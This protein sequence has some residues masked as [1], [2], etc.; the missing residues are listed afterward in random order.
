MDSAF[1]LSENLVWAL[2]HRAHAEVCEDW[3]S[4]ANEDV[5][6]FDVAMDNLIVMQ[7]LQCLE[8]TA[9]NLLDLLIREPLTIMR[10]E[11]ER[12]RV[13]AHE[14]AA[15][16]QIE[17]QDQLLVVLHDLVQ[18]AD[19]LRLQIQGL[20]VF[21]SADLVLHHLHKLVSDSH[22][23]A[24][25]ASLVLLL[26]LELKLLVHLKRVLFSVADYV[27]FVDGADLGA[28][29]LAHETILVE[30]LLP[31]YFCFGEVAFLWLLTEKVVVCLLC[32][33]HLI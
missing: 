14:L 2:Q 5:L 30:K 7:Q 20:Q 16:A 33:L 6:R 28:G 32:R 26:L 27:C 29:Q 31:I 19:T 21:E 15:L 13:P 10:S 22:A 8:Q 4:L 1:S 3:L 17:H 12:F 23:E 25:S 11:G 24:I 18:H 9:D